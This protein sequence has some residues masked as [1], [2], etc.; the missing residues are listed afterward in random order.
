MHSIDA[1]HHIVHPAFER[2]WVAA[3]HRLLNTR[4]VQLETYDVRDLSEALW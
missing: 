4:A 2:L 3:A 1:L